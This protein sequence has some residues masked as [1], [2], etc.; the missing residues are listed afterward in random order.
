LGQIRDALEEVSEST[1]DPKIKSE[2]QSLAENEF[3]FDFILAAVVWY[4]LLSAID[5]VSKRLQS[6]GAD[7]ST[8][9]TLLMGLK[10]FLQNF[11][12]NGFVSSKEMAQKFAMKLEYHLNSNG[13]GYLNGNVF[14]I[15]KERTQRRVTTNKNFIGTTFCASWIKESCQLQKESNYLSKTISGFC[16]ISRH[17]DH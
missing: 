16:T 11:R 13:Q 17:W 10:E 7:L 6:M 15:M 5:K 1:K 4:E 9:I 3:N 14:T 8:A 12:E 2:T